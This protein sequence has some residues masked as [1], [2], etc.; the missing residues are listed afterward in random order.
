M[1][2]IERIANATKRVACSGL[3]H[4]KAVLLFKLRL[5]GLK[6]ETTLIDC[7]TCIAYAVLCIAHSGI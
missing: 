1:K 7:A 6:H 4:F 5:P 3:K 2:S